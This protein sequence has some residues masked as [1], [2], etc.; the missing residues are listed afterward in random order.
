MGSRHSGISL[1]IACCTC[2]VNVGLHS[3]NCTLLLYIFASMFNCLCLYCPWGI[4]CLVVLGLYGKRMADQA[5]S[6]WETLGNE[7]VYILFWCIILFEI[8]LQYAATNWLAAPARALPFGCPG[9]YLHADM[10]CLLALMY[11]FVYYRE[12][13]LGFIGLGTFGQQFW[14]AWD[15]TEAKEKLVQQTGRFFPLDIERG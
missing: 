4:I 5:S 3:A 2:S 15:L 11:S 9:L 10:P 8:V 7:R 14:K 1:E 6:D 13:L 12:V